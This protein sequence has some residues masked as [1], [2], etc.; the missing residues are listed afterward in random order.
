MFV[1]AIPVLI[2]IIQDPE[3]RSIEN[4]SATENAISAVTKICKYNHGNVNVAEVLPHW[5][6]W[7]PTWEDEDEAEHIYNYLSELIEG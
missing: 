4:L 7:L 2:K 6:S 5:L 3:S 1:E